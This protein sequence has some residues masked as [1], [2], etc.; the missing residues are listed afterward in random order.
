MPLKDL[1]MKK[2]KSFL[3]SLDL[4]DQYL[5]FSM[6]AIFIY[7]LLM[8]CIHNKA[9]KELINQCKE[10]GSYIGKETKYF[11]TIGCIAK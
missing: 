9:E 1:I 8:I 6:I 3:Q 7:I 10:Y 5:I 4:M 2:I 11:K